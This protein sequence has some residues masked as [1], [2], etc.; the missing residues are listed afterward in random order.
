ML[1]PNPEKVELARRLYAQGFTIRQIADRIN[2]QYGTAKRYVDPA[3][4]ELQRQRGIARKKRYGGTCEICGAPTSYSGKKSQA[5]KRCQKHANAGRKFWTQ[6]NVIK[7]IQR[8]AQEYGR[9]PTSVDWNAALSKNERGPEYPASTTVQG[10][11]GAFKTWADAI[12]AAGFSRPKALYTGKYRELVWSKERT[13]E[14]LREHSSN[15]VAPPSPSW[16]RRAQGRPTT[17]WVA[18]LFGSWTKA[19]HEAG[20]V[21]TRE[22]KRSIRK[23]TSTREYVDPDKEAEQL[24]FVRRL[25]DDRVLRRFI[26]R[27]LW[28]MWK[29][30][31]HNSFSHWL[32]KNGIEEFAGHRFRSYRQLTR[33]EM[34]EARKLMV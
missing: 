12:E 20:L 23:K 3:Y 25:M 8:W 29:F 1:S 26:V 31:S 7:A 30:P 15:G 5:S 6:E 21:T 24:A 16:E 14:A 32:T 27:Q 22:Y 34:E 28:Q 19:C 10:E 9:P 4:D 11:H 18:Y 17:A 33:A 2:T 13:L